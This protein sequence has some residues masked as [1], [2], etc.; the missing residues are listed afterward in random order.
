MRKKAASNIPIILLSTGLVFILL[1]LTMIITNWIVIMGVNAGLLTARPGTPLIPFLIQTGIIS[2]C[3]GVILTLGLS[4]F[5]LRPVSQLIHAIHSVAGGDFQTKIHL[6]H[7]REFR[8]LSESF[9][10]MTDELSGIE[11]LRS[12]FINNFSHEFKTPIVSIMGFARL[13]KRNDLEDNEKEEYLNIIISECR[14]LSDLSA[15]VLNLSK[16]ESITLLSDTV[17]YNAAEQIRESILQLERKW[18]QKGI[19][20]D[21]DLEDCTVTGRPD[22]MKQV[23]V[24]LIDNAVKFSPSGGSISICTA[25]EGGEFLFKIQDNGIG[26]DTQ[27]QGKIF[28]RFYQGDISHATDGNGL[29]LSL[30]RKITELH[31][32]RIEVRS[33]PGK[34]STFI[35]SLPG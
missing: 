22:L 17:P 10:Q 13:L 18:D 1:F 14:R 12:D 34:G 31:N 6:K 15:N 33:T 16:V 4:Y 29:G 32:G 2:I 27:T 26:M 7:P 19:Q 3:I 23:W 5:P 35:I 21:L 25:K 30:V 20:F 8:E 9:N 11:I 28:D 24:N